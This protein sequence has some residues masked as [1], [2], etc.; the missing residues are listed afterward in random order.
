MVEISLII[1]GG[2]LPGSA[3]VVTMDNSQALR[4][5]LHRIF[6]DVL[7]L[8]VSIKIQLGAGYRA[9]TRQFA[10]SSEKNCCLYV[11]LDNKRECIPDWFDKLVTENP[12]KPIHILDDKRQNVF[13]MI[14]EMEAWILKQPAA[15][16]RWGKDNHYIRTHSNEPIEGHSLIAGKNIE[17]INKP[18]NTLG[19]IIKHFFSK[20]R[21]GKL[22]KVQYGKLKSAPGLL[23]CL[24]ATELKENDAELQRFC[25]TY[26]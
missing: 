10:A 23:D 1:E 13:F 5:S 14:Q 20:E 8:E 6:K 24:N 4:Q 9:A 19:E 3:D 17:D 18:S 16:E 12:G 26:S 21:D 22:K 15:I 11:D 25:A 7:G 2:V